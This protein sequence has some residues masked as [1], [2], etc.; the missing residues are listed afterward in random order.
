MLLASAL[1]G[2][3]AASTAAMAQSN[4]S[5]AF[6]AAGTTGAG[7][8]G[9]SGQT[10]EVRE[11]HGSQATSGGT[12]NIQVKIRRR[13]L[14]E[15]NSPSAVT[16]LGQKQI[17]Q[18]GVTGSPASL[19]RQAPS[20][21]VYS[22]GIGNNEPVLSI[23]G[24]RG[25]E[26][27]QTLDG[28]PMQDLLQGG[29]GSYLSNLIGGKFD[30]S[31]IS[32]VSIY[33]GVAY[34]N[35]NTFGTIGGTIA[36]QSLRPSDEMGA[37]LFGSVGSFGT[38]QEGITLN[39]GKLDGFLGSGYDAPKFMVQYTNLQTKGFIDYTPARYNNLEFAFD[40]PYDS[41]LSKFQATVLYNTGS[42]YYPNE[43]IPVPYLQ[44]NGMFSNYSP[45]Q[46]FAK[47]SN[48][49]LTVLL[50][51]NTYVND[52]LTVGANLFYEYTN[53]Q[54]ETYLNA[55]DTYQS[56]ASPGNATVGGAPPFVTGIDGFGEYP[57]FGPGGPFYDPAVGIT[58]DGNA[59]FP[60]G[61]PVARPRCPPLPAVA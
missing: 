35:E 2:V 45:D 29:T 32:G 22:S 31:Q 36:Y 26:T 39:S 33:P 13:L 41:G 27:A 5:A 14:R 57:D 20:V 16:E 3:F 9:V 1:T 60:A 47:Q 21:N 37:D 59:R 55:A 50:S 49:Y 38:W 18:V 34:P 4:Q 46:D 43:P 11:N 6:P 24:L 51:N 12:E 52:W 53:S 25:L 30:L 42:G 19:L 17:Q 54:N 7:P 48:Q 40:K 28:V 44:Q 58:Y 61:S 8:N 15:R 56:A 23:R 10:S